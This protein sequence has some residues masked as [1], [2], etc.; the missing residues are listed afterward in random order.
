MKSTVHVSVHCQYSVIKET[1]FTVT[2]RKQLFDYWT[3]KNNVYSHSSTVCTR[4]RPASFS[5]AS[6]VED[7][8]T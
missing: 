4:T 8:D 6:H 3:N 2:N 5:S 7:I 1:N